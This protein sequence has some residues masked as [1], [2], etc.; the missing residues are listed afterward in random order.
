MQS[1]SGAPIVVIGA[2]AAG[3]VAALFAR[4]AGAP[5]VLVEGMRDGGRKILIAGGGRCNILP[6]E[7]SPARFVTESS[8]HT[9]RKILQAWPL[10]GQIAFFEQELAMP[11]VLEV[12]T[13]KY[14]PETHRARDVRDRLLDRVREAGV[15]CR[16]GT[17]VTGLQPVDSGWRV[18]LADG[19]AL[20]A[21]AVIAATGGLSVPSTGSDGA[22]I[23]FLRALGHE[24]VPPYPALTPLTADPPVH[25]ELAGISL[26]VRVRAGRFET[27]GGFL[28]THRGYSGP[29]VLD[30]SHLVTRPMERGEVPESLR[31]QWSSHNAAA[32][33][34]RL[35]T[36]PARV[37]T[38]VAAELPVRL[39]D[40][41]LG[42]AGIPQE[43]AAAQLDR[44][45][46][47]A[48]VG[49]LTDYPLPVTGHEGYRKGEVTGGGLALAEIDP[50][51][52]ASRRAPGLFVAGEILDA[53][54]PIGG[55]NF[56]WAWCTGRAAG[57]GAAAYGL[58]SPSGLITVRNPN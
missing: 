40:R 2:G 33:D 49:L 24:I 28:F 19:S 52:M 26:P 38:L 25:A 9:V 55:H 51:T 14:F 16:F 21:R 53:F 56:C 46:R 7:V 50:R 12:E 15:V 57:E 8:P 47:R 18:E 20:D 5:V 32:W 43:M 23:G 31:V 41:L 42:E 36:G 34:E 4:R 30:A 45:R 39:A 37:R 3:I 11:L 48:L 35:R 44:A 10:E 6:S 29:A 58:G 13:G 27:G 17:R 54:G 1:D 22:G